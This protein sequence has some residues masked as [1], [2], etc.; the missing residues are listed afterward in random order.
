MASINTGGIESFGPPV[1]VPLLAQPK[2]I[3]YNTVI[4]KNF[5]NVALMYFFDCKITINLLKKRTIRSTIVF[6][7]LIF[8]EC[9]TGDTYF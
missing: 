7:D 8:S 4:N 9:H 5:K 6:F 1:G 2:K 3:V